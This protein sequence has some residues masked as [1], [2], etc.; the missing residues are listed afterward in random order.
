[1]LPVITKPVEAERRPGCEASSPAGEAGG[2]QS[3]PRRRQLLRRS[4]HRY[5]AF[6]VAGRR[7]ESLARLGAAA[8]AAVLSPPDTTAVVSRKTSA[9]RRRSKAAWQCQG[10]WASGRS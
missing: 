6:P 8:A 5:L 2:G 4:L 7:G 3:D 9:S 1:M 10:A